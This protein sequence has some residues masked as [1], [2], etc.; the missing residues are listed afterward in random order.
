[1]SRIVLSWRLKSLV[2]RLTLTG[3]DITISRQFSVFLLY[4]TIT[5]TQLRGIRA[6]L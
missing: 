6:L 2:Q 3:S 5:F 1:M 4:F